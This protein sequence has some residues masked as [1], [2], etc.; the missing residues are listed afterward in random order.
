MILNKENIDFKT[1]CARCVGDFAQLHED[2]T[3]KNNNAP[4]TLDCIYLQPSV[5]HHEGHD[6]LNLQ[7]NKIK[8]RKKITP[9]PMNEWFIKKVHSIAKYE[10]MPKG[11]KI[12]CRNETFYFDSH[13][14]QE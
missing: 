7:T 4:K 9:V 12:K 5:D 1:Q 8:N 6:L 14:M 2:K 10:S 11:L 3:I 13:C